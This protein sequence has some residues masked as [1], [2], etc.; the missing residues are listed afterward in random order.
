MYFLGFMMAFGITMALTPLLITHAT[1]LGFLDTPNERKLHQIPIARGGGVAFAI[2]VLGTL[3]FWASPN[4]LVRASVVG[5]L[6]LVIFGLWDDKVNLSYRMKLLGQFLAAGSVIWW[7]ELYLQPFPFFFGQELPTWVTIPL[8]TVTLLTFINSVNLSDGLDGLAGGLCVISFLAVGYLAYL[9]NDQFV[10]LIAVIVLGGLLGFLRFNT[11]PARIFMGDTGS[12][13]LGFFLGIAA[14]LVTHPVRGPYSP[15]ILLFLLG[16]PFWDTCWVIVRRLQQGR[17]PFAPDQEHLHHQFLKAGFAHSEVVLLVYVLQSALVVFGCVARWW[18]DFMVVGAFA[19]WSVAMALLVRGIHSPGV[20]AWLLKRQGSIAQVASLEP[21]KGRYLF[22][23]WMQEAWPALL[24]ASLGSFLLLSVLSPIHVP[25]AVGLVSCGML[26]LL[27]AAMKFS[28][29]ILPVCVRL[30]LY[31]GATF[32]VYLYE[33]HFLES[34]FLSEIFLNG[35]IV[36]MGISLVGSLFL[37][38]AREHFSLSP[39]DYLVI[40]LTLLIPNLPGLEWGEGA[41]KFLPIK[42]IVLFFTFEFVLLIY[43]RH[44]K[45]IAWCSSLTLVALALRALL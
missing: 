22:P 34:G 42:L 35:V 15:A 29:G 25:P 7:G 18:P 3:M 20:Q 8:T 31:I 38:S 32:F 30:A 36:F 24:G 39:L 6:I 27:V 37:K 14:L 21:V 2:A 13:F 1:T 44:T 33:L 12:Q 9:V 11:F 43:K 17:S 41:F 23:A 40:G 4:S 5:G 45:M 28:P 26:G 16:L 19:L 10:F